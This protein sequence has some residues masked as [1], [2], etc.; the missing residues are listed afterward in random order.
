MILSERIALVTGAATGIGRATVLSWPGPAPRR[1]RQLPVVPGPGGKSCA[2]EVR[3]LG[4]EALCVHGDVR[5]DGHVRGMVDQTVE[6]FGRLDILVNKRRITA[7]V[8]IT[9]MDALTDEIWDH[10][11][12]RQRQGRVYR[13]ARPGGRR[14]SR[15]PGA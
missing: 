9:D 5:D 2:E 10:D 1:G 7:G 14:T 13:C 8:P 6:R 15:P 3:E 4:V 12:G 11:P